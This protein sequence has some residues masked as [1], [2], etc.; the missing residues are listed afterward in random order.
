MLVEYLQT[1]GFRLHK[2]TSK[3]YSTSCPRCGGKNR[4]KIFLNLGRRNSGKYWCRQCHISGDYFS[5]RID[6]AGENK[7]DVLRELK[8]GKVEKLNKLNRDSTTFQ[9]PDSTSHKE[10]D[11][12]DWNT[13][14][15]F[16]DRV[17]RL[18]MQ[19]LE[20]SLAGQD[21]YAGRGITMETARDCRFG[22]I[23]RQHF[24]PAR[25]TG[26][27]DGKQ[28]CIPS[29]ACMPVLNEAGE[30]DCLLV[31]RADRSQWE[32]WGKF[33]QIGKRDVPFLLGDMGKPLVLCESILD[34]VSVW[35]STQGW[36]SA[37]ALL[38]ASKKPDARL[39]KYI[40][41]ARHVL[42]CADSDDGGKS[43]CAM[44]LGMR[45]DAKIWRPHGEGIK[46]I[47]DVLTKLGADELGL[48]IDVGLAQALGEGE[49]F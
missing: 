17:A 28:T 46:D 41:A 25:E 29:G 42:V 44:A 40:M 4:L 5:W 47:N 14:R 22:W 13:F 10:Q 31:R 49:E 16:S 12:H 18:A 43:L 9:L 2:D 11:S 35:Q 24:F 1:Q 20:T 48:F 21:F 26:R 30:V 3:E 33:C 27:I 8:G 38:G 39:T 23:A 37:A 32:Q 45:P 6:I 36:R 19:T 34:A 7:G 15:T